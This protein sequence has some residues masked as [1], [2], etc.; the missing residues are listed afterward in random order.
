L[1]LNETL[2]QEKIATLPACP[3]CGKSEA[4]HRAGFYERET[5]RS[6][7]MFRC[8][9][10]H[11]GCGSEFAD[12]QREHI[13]RGRPVN[14]KRIARAL[15]MRRRG[16]LYRQ[17]G[18]AMG[19][20]GRRAKNLCDYRPPTSNGAPK[21]GSRFEIVVKPEHVPALRGLFYQA[22]RQTPEHDY[23]IA[24][25]I[26]DKLEADLASFTLAHLPDKLDGRINN[27]PHGPRRK[28]FDAF[29]IVALEKE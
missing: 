6:V 26:S 1:V 23:Q 16:L 14:L 5:G 24:E 18:A 25:F 29:T 3:R 20:S 10:N 8:K 22:M 11:G 17:I 28:T 13:P 15:A 7:Q 2:T 12:P 4:T 9:R 27:G 19:I 21:I